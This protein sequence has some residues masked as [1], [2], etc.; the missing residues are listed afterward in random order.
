MN[1]VDRLTPAPVA[2]IVTTVAVVTAP[3]EIANPPLVVAGTEATAGL[4]LVN[5]NVWPYEE[6]A[7]MFTVPV[8]E[9]EFD[10][11]Q[12]LG[13]TVTESGARDGTTVTVVCWLAPL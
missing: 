7:A 8:T 11:I 5:W 13:V 6:K 2:V 12:E 1:C 3:V 9:P 4:L 10:P